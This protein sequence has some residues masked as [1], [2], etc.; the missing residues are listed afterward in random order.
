MEGVDPADEDRGPRKGPVESGPSV[1]ARVL[2][3]ASFILASRII[4]AASLFIVS[5]TLAR[6]LGTEQYGLIAI[7]LGMAGMLEVVGALG[8]NTGSS[9]YI[10]FY[11]AKGRGEDVRRVIYINV[12]TKI[13]M[14]VMLGALLYIAAGFMADLFDKPVE[15]LVQI[16]A[17]VLALNVLSGAFQGILRG[18]ERLPLM[19]LANVVR[20]VVWSVTAIT[21][22]VVADMGPEGA[23]WGTVAGAIMFLVLSLVGL[24]VAL[25]SEVPERGRLEN[26]YDRKVLMALITFG[27]PVLLSKLLFLVFDWTGTYVV[28]YF[29][30]VEDVSIYN[31]AFGI[32]AIPLVLIKAIGV[33]MLPAMSRAYGEDRLGLMRTLW[34]GSLKLINSLFIPLTAMLMVLAA[35]AILLI[36]GVD[37]VPGAMAVLILAPYLLVRPTGI[38]SNHILAAMARQDIIFKVNMASVAVNIGMSIVLMP[39]IGIE[40]VAL[41]ASCAFILNSLL[42]YHFARTKA[43]V[44]VDHGAM[45]KI[46]AGAVMAMAVG[47]G[48]FWATE[49]LGQD[50]VFLFM[51][52]G[53]ATLLGLG[54]YLVYIRRVHIFTEDEM[55]NVRSV[56]EHSK[57]AGLILKTLGQ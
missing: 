2:H 13:G 18:F 25:R 26:R 47:A 33:A 10:P 49:F 39:A 30:T 56:A 11:Q 9:R 45:G 54:L 8:L 37:Y 23:L 17:I 5:V 6:Y 48:V 51:R 53:A 38:T 42:L 12:T 20:D 50:F 14:A 55:E 44:E 27:I 35:P 4:N 43:G 7:A 1:T 52:L 40:G 34:G 46:L 3:G 32:V 16:A 41:A 22:V 36:Y 19:A 31:I 28:A 21:L 57:L 24:A 29:G 15:P